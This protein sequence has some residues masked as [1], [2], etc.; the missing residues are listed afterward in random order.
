MVGAVSTHRRDLALRVDGKAR[1]RSILSQ[2]AGLRGQRLLLRSNV[3]N[4]PRYR[5]LELHLRFEQSSVSN[6]VA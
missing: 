3:S 5:L 6:R 4:N 1:P 2:I